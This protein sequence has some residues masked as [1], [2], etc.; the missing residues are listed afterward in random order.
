[1]GPGL[2][3]GRQRGCSS[4]EEEAEGMDCRVERGSLRPLEVKD[5]NNMLIIVCF[6]DTPTIMII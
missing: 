2:R 3:A 4:L 5:K 1:M 6:G